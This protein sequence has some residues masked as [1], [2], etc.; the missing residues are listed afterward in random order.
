MTHT[1][2]YRLFR[3]ILLIGSVFISGMSQGMLMTT[4]SILLEKQGLSSALNGF[5]AMSLYIG[6]LIAAPL[7]EKPTNKYGYK[8]M[9]LLGL[10][11]TLVPIF[12]FPIWSYFWF[13]FALRLIIGLGDNMLHFAAQVWITVSSPKEKKGRNIAF[14]GL[15]YGLGFAIGPLIASSLVFGLYLPFLI[16]GISCLLFFIPMLFIENDF[17]EKFVP[18]KKHEKNYFYRHKK[19]LSLAWSGLVVTFTYGFLEASLNSNFPVFALRQGLNLSDISIILPTFVLGSLLTQV[20]LGSIGDKIGRR[21]LILIVTS[22]GACIFI[23]SAIFSHS[24]LALLITFFISGMLVGSLFSMGMTYLSDILKPS[25][26]PLA[27]IL[28]GISFSLGS[29]TGPLVGGFLIKYVPNG[30]FLYGIAGMMMIICLSM[31]I[32]GRTKNIGNNNYL[33]HIDSNL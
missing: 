14:Y 4:L 19:I 1:S 22:L 16:A 2:S 20:P 32:S 18:N 13:W 33:D 21:I 17:P 10:L 31:V 5:N 23:I 29:M 27:N 9:L 26:I 15:S 25:F 7:I 11:L 30:S 28:A 8:P 3:F 6:V 24:F 12:L